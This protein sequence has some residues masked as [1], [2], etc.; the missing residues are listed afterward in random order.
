MTPL[1]NTPEPAE[2]KLAALIARVRRLEQHILKHPEADQ[3]VE[4][5]GALFKRHPAGGYHQAVFCMVCGFAMSHESSMY[6]CIPC[7]RTF[8]SEG[9]SLEETLHALPKNK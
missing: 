8:D 2:A 4:Y 5:R 3:F 9:R 1:D 7:K 6:V